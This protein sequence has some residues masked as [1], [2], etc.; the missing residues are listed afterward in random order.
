MQLKILAEIKFGSRVLNY[1]CKNV[2]R[3]E[4]SNLAQDYRMFTRTFGNFSS[5][6]S[7]KSTVVFA[8]GF[9]YHMVD[10]FRGWKFSTASQP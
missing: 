3:F 4:F 7:V 9:I 6:V 8:C 5:L 1:L 2:D 10:N